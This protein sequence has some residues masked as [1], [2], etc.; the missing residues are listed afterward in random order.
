M[1][2]SWET[3]R[4]TKTKKHGRSKYRMNIWCRIVL[5]LSLRYMILL[6]ALEVTLATMSKEELCQVDEVY[7]FGFVPSYLLPKKRPIS[8][9]PFMEPFIRDIEE[10]FINGK[11]IFLC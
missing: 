6:S 11:Y 4:K 3:R 1:P 9:D 5:C 7:V 2:I 10:G 8:F